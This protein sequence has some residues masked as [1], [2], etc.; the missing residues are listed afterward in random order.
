MAEDF[1]A[2]AYRRLRSLVGAVVGRDRAQPRSPRALLL[3][4]PDT[5]VRVVL[6]PDLPDEAYRLLLDVDLSRIHRGP[7]HYDRH[8][9]R[10]RSPLDEVE[11]GR[12]STSVG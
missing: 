11:S 8:G 1:A 2:D 6:E 10:W 3:Q 4:D 7:L 5:G 9:R 12:S